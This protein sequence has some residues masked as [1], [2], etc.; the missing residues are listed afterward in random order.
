MMSRQAGK[1]E[2]SAQ[3]EAYFLNLFQSK[4]G[5]IVK[6]SPTLKPQAI[7]SIMRLCDRLE[8]GLTSGR[9]RKREG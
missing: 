9:Y 3:I 2:L 7:K 4:G 5:Q 6:A 1:N 8:N